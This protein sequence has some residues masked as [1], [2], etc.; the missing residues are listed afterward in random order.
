MPNSLSHRLSW[1]ESVLGPSRF[2]DSQLIRNAA[3]AVVAITCAL[4]VGTFVGQGKWLYLIPLAVLPLVARWPVETALGLFAIAIPFDEIAIVGGSGGG[5]TSLTFFVGAAAASI[6]C[7]VGLAHRRFRVPPRAALWWSLFVLWCGIS[8]LW[9]IDSAAARARMPTAGALLLIYLLSSSIRLTQGE[10]RWVVFLTVLG[11]CLGSAYVVK[12]FY[13]GVSLTGTDRASLVVAGQE[14]DPNG[15]AAGLL[16]P[17][18]LAMALFFSNR[19]RIGKVLAVLALGG[20]GLCIF[21]SM[22]RG[23]ALALI[24][25]AAIYLLR[26]KK[27][28]ALVPVASLLLLLVFVPSGFFTRFQEAGDTGG[29]GR[30]PIWTAGLEALKHFWVQ[31]AG[32]DGF[33]EAY[34]TYAGFAPKFKGF[35]RASHNIYLGTSVELGIVGFTFLLLA[36]R[37]QFRAVRHAAA[38]FDPFL[39]GS[40]AA[41]WAILVAGFFLDV[42]WRKYFWLSWIMLNIFTQVPRETQV[43]PGTQVRVDS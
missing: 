22:S 39:V 30:V 21:L 14:A 41:C 12:E 20:I 43:R 9:A 23:A 33:P 1:K 11:G 34:T 13:Q 2:G 18:S 26:L 6:L 3:W 24:V 25:I 36:I 37:S 28:R 29:A 31:G 8:C 7:L 10:R 15:L 38:K 5:G 40:E 4:V 42:L 35:G 17:T 19:K 16:L 27:W 32:I